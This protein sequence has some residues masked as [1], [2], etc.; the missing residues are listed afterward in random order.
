MKFGR[1]LQ[2]QR[3]GVLRETLRE[4]CRARGLDAGNLSRIERGLVF[5]RARL[6]KALCREYGIPEN[7]T[8]ASEVYLREQTE[9]AR[10]AFG[11]S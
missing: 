7:S 6:A 9:R 4:F 8:E 5:P 1:Y 3:I 2:A 11:E 10:I